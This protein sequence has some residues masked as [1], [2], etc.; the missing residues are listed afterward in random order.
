M[1]GCMAFGG[2]FAHGAVGIKIQELERTD[3]ETFLDE[4]GLQTVQYDGERRG[5]LLLGKPGAA[6]APSGSTRSEGALSG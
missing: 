2:R 4:F 3:F 1:G 6:Q 5:L